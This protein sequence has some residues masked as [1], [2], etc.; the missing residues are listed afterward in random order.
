[1]ETFAEYILAEKDFG[2]K[3]EIMVYLKRKVSSAQN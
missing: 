3:I 1:M 2:R